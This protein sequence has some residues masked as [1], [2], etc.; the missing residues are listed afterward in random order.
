MKY[1]KYFEVTKQIDKY[2]YGQTNVLDQKWLVAP[3][4][5]TPFRERRGLD[6]K[7]RMY[8]HRRNIFL[9]SLLVQ[10]PPYNVEFATAFAY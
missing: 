7:H 3:V 10:L 2:F 9:P 6:S 8:K 1:H 4:S 5:V